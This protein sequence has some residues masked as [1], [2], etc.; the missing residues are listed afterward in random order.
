MPL[1]ESGLSTLV[2]VAGSRLTLLEADSI[3]IAVAEAHAAVIGAAAAAAGGH[4]HGLGVN[5]TAAAAV[6]PPAAG[7]AAAVPPERT[8]SANFGQL[9]PQF[10]ALRA[11]VLRRLLSSSPQL[12][13]LAPGLTSLVIWGE[14]NNAGLAR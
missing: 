5:A 9:G 2:A 8:A 7:A 10:P 14:A 12:W 13:Q 6:M 1:T 4:M 11:L 3:E